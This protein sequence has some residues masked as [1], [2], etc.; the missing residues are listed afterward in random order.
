MYLNVY[1][2]HM[3][4]FDALHPLTESILASELQLFP[5]DIQSASYFNDRTNVN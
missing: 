3:I 4:S 5:G 2:S 1:Q